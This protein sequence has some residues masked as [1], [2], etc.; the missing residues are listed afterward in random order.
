MKQHKVS[1]QTLNLTKKQTKNVSQSVSWQ[2]DTRSKN[3]VN[4]N[5]TRG[6]MELYMGHWKVI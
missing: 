1:K 2:S 4:T 5:Y 6:H 3:N